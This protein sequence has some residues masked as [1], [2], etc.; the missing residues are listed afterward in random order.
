MPRKRWQDMPDRTIVSNCPEHVK[1]C[2]NS[3]STTKYTL[4]TFI[5]MNL[6]EQFSKLA[7]VYFLFIGMMQMINEISISNG[8]PVIYVPLFVVLM[9]S[10]I[11]DL[12]EDMKRN[13]SD[14]EENQRLVWTYRNGMWIRVYWQSLLVG[15]IVKVE[16]NQ[17]FP[18]DILCMYTTDSKGLCYVETKNL[19]G[20]T[21]L[22]RKISNK[23]LQQLG[24]AAILHQKFTFNCEKPNPYLYKF[25]GNMEITD[26]YDQQQ[27]ISLDYNNF[28]LRGC[29]LKN[30][31]YVIGLVS[32]TGRDSKIMM[33]TVNARSKRSHIEKKMNVFISLVFLLQIVVCLSFALGAAIWFNQ[34]KSSLIFMLG[35]SS[36]AEIDN[37]FGYLLVVQWGAWILIFT[38]FVPISLIVTLEM[39]KFMQGIRITQDPNTYSKT[40]DIQCTVQCSGLNEELGQVE[41][42][43]SDK[44]GTLTSNT[45][46]YK[47]LTVNGVSYGEQDNMT[48]QELIDKP[49]VTN[50]KFL[51]KKLFEDMQGKKAMGSEQQQHLFTALKV[52]SAC[53][54][55]ITEKTSEGIEYNAS[56]PDELALINFAKFCGF[57][58]LGI[59]EDSVMRIKQENI[60]HRFKVLNV[61]D[62]NS[63]RKR[64]SI[65]VEDSNGKIFLFCKGADSVLQKLL[66]QKLNEDHIIEQTWINLERY[67]SVGLRTLVLAQKE[68]QKDEYHLWNEQ[69]QVA[70]CSLKD[71]EE[72]MERLQKKIEKNLILVGATAIE[73]QLQDEVSSTIQL[74]K[75]AGI[76]VWVLTGDKV[77]TAVNIGYACSLL[78]DQLRRILVDG[79]SLE[80]VQKSLQAA[81]KSILNEVENHNQTIL[82]SNRKKSQKNEMIKNFSLDLALILTGDAL[83]H[84]T[85]NKENNE[86]LMKISEHCKVVLACRV[87]PKQKQEIVHLVRVAKPESTTLAIGDGANDV[88]MISAAHVG[89]GIR[90]KEGQQAARASDFAV[91]EFKILKSL[92]F[93]HGRESYRKNSTLI[94]YN[95]YK[96]MLLVL[97]Q[98]WYAFISGYSGSS[99]Y[100]PWIY[101]LYNMCYTSLPIVVYAIF[102]QEFSDEYLVE[103]PDLYVQGIKGLLFNQREYWLWIINGSWHA[104]LSCFISFVG[105]DGTFQVNGKDFFFQAT[106]TVTFGA[107]VFIG[108]LKVYIFSNTYNPALLISVF[109]SIIFYISNHGLASYFYVTSDIFNTFSNTYSSPYFWFCS[110]IIIGIATIFDS[111]DRRWEYF[112]QV[113]KRQDEKKLALLNEA[114][115]YQQNEGLNLEGSKS[116]SA[117]NKNYQQ[118]NRDEII[119]CVGMLKN[120]YQTQEPINLKQH[121]PLYGEEEKVPS[122]ESLSNPPY[123]NKSAKTVSNHQNSHMNSNYLTST[124]PYTGYAFSQIEPI[125]E[126]QQK[127]TY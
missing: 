51:D 114:L 24:E 38:N 81:Y 94:C 1:F 100:D 82:Q 58:Y 17:L 74:M 80:E 34:N 21:N 8:Q 42:V 7:N 90:G 16:K 108:N 65:I 70:C 52:L 67:A 118:E 124:K 101:Q 47:C 66:D 4:F 117:E 96:N 10:G 26:G 112:S 95:F 69:Y 103:N 61:L 97:P 53:H 111:T 107:T 45:M 40:Y 84:C 93:N 3:I 105:L 27:K 125:T 85:E 119:T 55:V 77:E 39:V 121:K 9:I 32:Y 46:K 54:T 22:K 36:T 122:S 13:K 89:V 5:P 123:P 71:R 56:S 86:T 29:S 127:Y 33:N 62:F 92:L 31:D 102:D 106:G 20:E 87:S 25:Q 28:I 98:W 126:A 43:F 76:K 79:Y 35:V 99:M 72:E 30:T 12:F 49:N 19:D 48:E 59:D 37:S 116:N 88:N 11:K 6:V 15:E 113:L 23:S 109:G 68:I 91:G 41:Y 73:D 60:M 2:N 44:T 63:V 110:I 120:G 78:N 64:M 14:Q 115:T 57:E 75:K 104:F 83:I 50:V 18:A